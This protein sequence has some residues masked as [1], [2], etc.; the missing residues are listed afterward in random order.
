[1]NHFSFFR[2]SAAL[3]AWLF[4]ALLLAGPAVAEAAPV[5][6]LAFTSDSKGKFDPCPT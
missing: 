5:L 1:M 3:I 2:S 4:A 6:T